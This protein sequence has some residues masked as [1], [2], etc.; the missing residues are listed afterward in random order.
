MTQPAIKWPEGLYLPFRPTADPAGLEAL[1]SGNDLFDCWGDPLR[2]RR[3]S[4]P[5]FEVRDSLD[6]NLT[7]PMC[8]LRTFRACDRIRVT[9]T[10]LKS[11]NGNIAVPP[12][13]TFEMKLGHACAGEDVTVTQAI[14][15]PAYGRTG[16]IFQASELLFDTVQFWAG[17]VVADF[18]GAVQGMVIRVIVDRVGSGG[19]SNAV[20][21][22]PGPFA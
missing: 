12:T 9:L 5:M 13:I 10:Q 8:G 11:L 16:L 17:N 2:Q 4:M 19:A 6:A 22:I 20:N 21:V 18:P 14:K 7:Q 3:I 15:C 1:D